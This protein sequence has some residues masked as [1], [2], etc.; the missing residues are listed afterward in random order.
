[1]SGLNISTIVQLFNAQF[2]ITNVN[3]KMLSLHVAGKRMT[4]KAYMSCINY[5]TICAIY[6]KYQTP[7][8]SLSYIYGTEPSRH[9][10]QKCNVS[11]K[12][13]ISNSDKHSMYIINIKK[14]MNVYLNIHDCPGY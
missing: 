9:K 7:E 11:K 4:N 1:M 14:K 10:F 8:I 13:Q 5:I 12:I 3:V 2:D 6:A